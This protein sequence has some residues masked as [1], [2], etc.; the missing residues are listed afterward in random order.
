VSNIP[1]N[2]KKASEY[3]EQV[4]NLKKSM[5]NCSP[6]EQ[7][8][9]WIAFYLRIINKDFSPNNLPSI[10]ACIH[11]DFY[12]KNGISF[13]SNLNWRTNHKFTASITQTDR[14]QAKNYTGVECIFNSMPKIRGKC[15][16]DHR[17][18]NSLGGPSI[19]DNRLILCRYHNGMKSNDISHFSWETVPNWLEN[20]AS[21]LFRLKS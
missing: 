10:F 5:A 8:A 14:C 12:F 7:D 9:I 21:K 16:A 4:Y 6:Q 15:Q 19:L 3:L 1:C 20:Y 17:W 2:Q 18:P 11:P 13:E